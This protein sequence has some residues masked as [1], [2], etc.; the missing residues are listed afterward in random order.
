LTR[1]GQSVT[2]FPE[3]IKR[4]KSEVEMIVEALEKTEQE[5]FDAVAEHLRKQGE[6]ALVDC[7]PGG[8]TC[9][10]RGENGLTCAWGAML[11]DAE[12]NYRLSINEE[13]NVMGGE[14]LKGYFSNGNRG[15]SLISALQDA[16]DS[17][18]GYKGDEFRVRVLSHLKEGAV[19][20][21]LNTDYLHN[22]Y[23]IYID[24]VTPLAKT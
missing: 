16:H 5:L 2:L 12:F 15:T 3:T 19:N 18:N 20:F 11:T 23:A 17:Q 7:V 8:S 24:D 4:K 1:S 22:I 21:N 6:A 14:D 13:E 10:Y 9:A